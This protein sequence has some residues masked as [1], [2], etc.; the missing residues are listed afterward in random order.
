MF[1]QFTRAARLAVVESIREARGQA[2]EVTDEHL[3]LALTNQQNT[4]SA[5]WLRAAGVTPSTI[6]AAFRA[7]ERKA[8]LSDAEAE[9]LLRELGI[10][11]D[12]IV[13]RVEQKLGENALAGAPRSRRRMPFGLVAKGIVRGAVE[14]ARSLRH[15]EPRDEHL[16]L[17]LA[18]HDGVA[19]QLLAAHGLS[20][21][22]VRARLARA[23]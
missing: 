22:D 20:Y 8:G 11:V 18:A 19:G 12:E 5:G 10:D 13:A 1:N 3:L 23:S 17:A 21:L 4:T 15:K 16:L 14:Q 9:L 2:V 7:A 6:D